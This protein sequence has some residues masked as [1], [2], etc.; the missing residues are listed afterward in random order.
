MFRK[1]SKKVTAALLAAVL[2]SGAGVLSASAAAKV[3]VVDEC[4]D[5]SKIVA[6]NAS[7]GAWYDFAV[8]GMGQVEQSAWE[9]VDCPYVEGEKFLQRKNLTGDGQVGGGW[10]VYGDTNIAS[11]DPFEIE[12]FTFTMNSVKYDYSPQVNIYVSDSLNPVDRGLPIEIEISD[13]VEIGTTGA[14]KTWTFTITPAG[15]LP[16]GT[17]YV[18]VEC[19]REYWGLGIRKAEINPDR[20]VTTTTKPAATTTKP[21]TTTTSTPA[22]SG[23]SAPSSA[24]GTV[25]STRFEDNFSSGFDKTFAHTEGL[26][27][28]PNPDLKLDALLG[29]TDAAVQS[30]TY[31]LSD[32][33]N[34]TDGLSIRLEAYCVTGVDEAVNNLFAYVSED[35]EQWTKVTLKSSQQ[36]LVSGQEY[37]DSCTLSGSVQGTPKFLKIEFK[38]NMDPNWLTCLGSVS[39]SSGNLSTGG[40]IPAAAISLAVF[41][42]AALVLVRKSYAAK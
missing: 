4:N 14:D 7:E 3:T 12:D 16:A 8:P 40:S 33:L 20:S 10:V 38:E 22:A 24:P 13:L 29:K 25:T 1:R 15:K 11:T 17:K 6:T 27:L 2:C 35:G 41:A 21:A 39:V 42:A 37:W 5:F 36:T 28:T 9:V 30:I 26:A 19:L 23:S 34:V 32:C 18:M 31:R